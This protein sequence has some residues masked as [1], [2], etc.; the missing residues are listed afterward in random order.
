MDLERHQNG[1]SEESVVDPETIAL[2]FKRTPQKFTK[3]IFQEKML[4]RKFTFAIYLK[5]S[6][7]WLLAFEVQNDFIIKKF[8]ELQDEFHAKDKYTKFRIEISFWDY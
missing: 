6:Y 3:I 2:D 7:I 8:R 1:D 5:R 4:T